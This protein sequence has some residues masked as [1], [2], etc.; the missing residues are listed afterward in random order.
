MLATRSAYDSYRDLQDANGEL[1]A[2]LRA[3]CVAHS[4][5]GLGYAKVARIKQGLGEDTKAVRASQMLTAL[6]SA[7]R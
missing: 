3:F 4:S 7:H 1:S 6:S 2:P 5:F